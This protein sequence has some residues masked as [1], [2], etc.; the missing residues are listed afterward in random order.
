MIMA[1]LTSVMNW[2][3]YGSAFLK[4]SRIPA[5]IGVK[6]ADYL[7]YKSVHVAGG[8][9]DFGRGRNQ[10]RLELR[11]AARVDHPLGRFFLL[12][13]AEELADL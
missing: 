6:V 10:I 3:K 1:A 13:A 4:I 2:R 8:F 9:G 12:E 5:V 11:V 7:L